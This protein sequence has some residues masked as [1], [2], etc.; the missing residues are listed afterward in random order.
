MWHEMWGAG[1]DDEERALGSRLTRVL[2]PRLSLNEPE[3]TGLVRRLVDALEDLT[4]VRDV[5][6]QWVEP[7]PGALPEVIPINLPVVARDALAELAR[8]LHAAQN[9]V[10][11]GDALA[12]RL[13]QP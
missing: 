1:V 13:A 10:V 8:L 6:D 12:D 3:L 2:L 9:V 7:F 5:L 11:R 4:D